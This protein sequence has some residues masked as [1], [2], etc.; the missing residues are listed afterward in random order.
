MRGILILIVV[1]LVV[2][3]VIGYERDWF[4]FSARAHEG[5]VEIKAGVN[6]EQWRIDRDKYRREAETR[7]AEM[8]KKL[9]E[10]KAKESKAAGDARTALKQTADELNKKCQAAQRELRELGD[11]GREHWE[12]VRNKL[13]QAMDDLKTGFEKAASHFR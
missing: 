8:S 7:L 2:V 9:D 13:G 1:A 4:N 11:A 10:L 3:G 12:A 5:Q 6:D